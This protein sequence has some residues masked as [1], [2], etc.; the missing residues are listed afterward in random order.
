MSEDQEWSRRVLLDGYE[1]RYVADAAVR[2]SH[3]YTLGAAFRRFFDSGVSASRSYAGG[4]GADRRR[5]A[6]GAR[7]RARR[8]RVAVADGQRALDPLR[9][10]LRGH[11]V[12]RPAARACVTSG[13]RPA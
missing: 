13:C 11:Q 4:E 3:D 2:H 8:A 12:R 1:L 5:P 6:P 7:L 10:A 9:R